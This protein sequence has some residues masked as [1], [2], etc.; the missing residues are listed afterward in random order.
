L[1]AY[2]D[3]ADGVDDMFDGNQSWYSI[4]GEQENSLSLKPVNQ[5]I[6][7]YPN[8][9]K[10]TININAEFNFAIIYSMN[11]Q[12][13]IKSYSKEIDLSELDKGFYLLKLVDNSN[14]II[15]LSKIL[16]D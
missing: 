1:T 12:E 5:R 7:F 4:F 11:G 8:P 13:M 15:G 2:T 3:Q 14:K 10:S 9:T 6:N 16:R